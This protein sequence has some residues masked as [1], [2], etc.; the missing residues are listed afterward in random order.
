MKR[1]PHLTA[2][3]NK[4]AGKCAYTGVDMTL[5]R[6]HPHTATIDH[7]IPK[8]VVGGRAFREYNHVA[9]C[10]WVNQLKSDR[11]LSEFIGILA[12]EK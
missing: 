8:S 10:D 9:C 7:V 5:D 1:N 3:F 4:Q 2:L 11:P 6:G 12:R